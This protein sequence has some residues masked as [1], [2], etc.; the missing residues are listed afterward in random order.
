MAG[1]QCSMMDNGGSRIINHH[2]CV[3][4][5]GMSHPRP[6]PWSAPK[7]DN[8]RHY[9]QAPSASS[10]APSVYGC[11]KWKKSPPSRHCY[12]DLGGS[13]ISYHFSHLEHWAQPWAKPLD[14]H[15]CWWWFYRHPTGFANMVSRHLRPAT[16]GEPLLPLRSDVCPFHAE[17]EGRQ[18]DAA[19]GAP[20]RLGRLYPL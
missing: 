3:A 12:H 2:S 7:V 14:V 19:C 9:P 18:E 8:S 17:G 13:I 10:L 4:T 15:G 6:N 11:F 1:K 5:F 16:S 20:S